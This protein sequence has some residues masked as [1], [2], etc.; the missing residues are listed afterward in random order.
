MAEGINVVLTAVPVTGPDILVADIKDVTDNAGYATPG[1]LF[2]PV[3]GAVE[4]PYTARVAVSLE[5]GSLAALVLAGTVTIDWTMSPAFKAAVVTG[6][7]VAYVADETPTGAIDA[8][9]TGFTILGAP[10]V[11]VGL[12]NNGQKLIGGG[13]DYTIV[14]QNITTVVAPGIGETLKADYITSLGTFAF[15]ADEVPVGV[16][17]GANASF[18]TA[19][20]PSTFVGLYLNGEK[21]I[22]GGVDYTQAGT[23]ITMN[24]APLGGSTLV[25]DY[26]Y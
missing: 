11:F 12:Y 22:S 21:Q 13:A 6:G 1:P 16:I 23:A 24:V 25:V 2:V 20:N 5:E 14:G 3:P 15:A 19:H 17:D 9:N 8:V 7:G 10:V 18:T 26:F 4:I